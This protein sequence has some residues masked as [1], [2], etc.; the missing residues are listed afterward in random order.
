MPDP[1]PDRDAGTKMSAELGV[2]DVDSE[3]LRKAA[4]E[5]RQ[6]AESLSPLLTKLES[7]NTTAERE[8][9]AFTETHDPAPIYRGAITALKSVG[10]KFGT[11]VNRLIDRLNSDAG[12]L[13]W[14]AE[15]HDHTEHDNEHRVKDLPNLGNPPTKSC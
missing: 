2:I 12:A 11:Q 6:H 8:A 14:I 7:I 10:E 1:S 4:R 13:M 15:T 5:L 9:S 3:V